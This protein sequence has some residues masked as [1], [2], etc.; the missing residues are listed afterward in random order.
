MIVAPLVYGTAYTRSNS[1]A[2]AA[3]GR[4]A[5]WPWVLV[6]VLGAVVPECLHRSLSDKDL[7]APAGKENKQT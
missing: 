7:D 4:F 3:A 1:A 2:A 5:G 6:A